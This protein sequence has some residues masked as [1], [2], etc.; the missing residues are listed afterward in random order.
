MRL[1]IQLL[2]KELER[3]NLLID[4][5]SQMW[6]EIEKQGLSSNPR[7]PTPSDVYPNLF[8]LRDELEQAIKILKLKRWNKN[9][10]PKYK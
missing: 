1:V 3:Q 5:N 9:E 7:G 8:G 4:T 10:A 6:E 2:E